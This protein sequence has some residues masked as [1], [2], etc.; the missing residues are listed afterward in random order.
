MCRTPMML[1]WL[2]YILRKNVAVQQE[3]C[4]IISGVKLNLGAQETKERNT[5]A[6]QL[7]KNTLSKNNKN[8]EENDQELMHDIREEFS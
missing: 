7:R 6:T 3:V 2:A 5:T 1:E 4:V 8:L